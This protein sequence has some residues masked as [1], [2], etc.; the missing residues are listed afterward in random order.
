[1]WFC[2][3]SSLYFH[4]MHRWG[5]SFHC[6]TR[7]EGSY[8]F[9]WSVRMR[10]LAPRPKNWWCEPSRALLLKFHVA[11]DCTSHICVHHTS[12]SKPLL[13]SKKKIK[14]ASVHLASLFACTCVSVPTP[15][16]RFIVR[17]CFSLTEELSRL[18]CTLKFSVSV[19]EWCYIF[20]VHIRYH[21]IICTPPVPN[22][23]SFWFY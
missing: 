4:C 1:M 18:E 12:K 20:C 3:I 21:T 15:A 14:Q 19:E 9:P 13:P 11:M 8:A 16:H 22:Y 23:N 6:R 17:H 5:F 2:T 7:L 10:S